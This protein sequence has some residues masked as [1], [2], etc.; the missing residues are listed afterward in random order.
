MRLP[1]N[2]RTRPPAVA[3]PRADRR[4]PARGRN[5]PRCAPGRTATT[6]QACTAITAARFP[7]APRP[8]SAAVGDPH[9]GRRAARLGRPPTPASGARCRRSA[10][11]LPLGPARGAAV[12][13]RTTLRSPRCICSRRVGRRDRQSTMHGVMHVVLVS[14][15]R[16][17]RTTPDA[18]LRE[19][20]GAASASVLPRS[21]SGGCTSPRSFSSSFKPV[22]PRPRRASEPARA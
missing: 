6:S 7:Q 4:L 2:R 9:E 10:I 12:P 13:T 11:R 8:R 14:R 21:P 17:S 15:R 3:D 16:R 20:N 22:A 19:A 18:V 1:D 5:G